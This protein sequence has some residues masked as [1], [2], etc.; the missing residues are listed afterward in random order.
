[1]KTLPGALRPLEAYQQFIVWKRVQRADRV[2]KVPI[3]HRTGR[4]ASAH[5]PAIWLS[6]ADAIAAAG[7]A[8]LGVGFTFTETD[9]FFFLDIDHC[10]EPGGWSPTALG[11]L[12]ALHG[13]AVEVS[14]SGEGLHVFGRTAALVHGTKNELLGLELYTSKR[15]VALTGDRAMGSADVDLTAPLAAI[16]AQHFPPPAAST[17]PAEWTTEPAEAGAGVSDDKDLIKRALRSKSA[18]GAFGAKCTF[19][20]LWAADPDRLAQFYPA[21]SPHKAYGDSEADA[22]LAQHLAFWTGGDCEQIHRLM[23]ASGLVREKWGREDYLY[24]TITNA[25]GVQTQYYTPKEN[26]ERIEE[27]GPTLGTSGPEKLAGYQ[28]LGPDAQIDHFRGCVYVQNLH[29][30]FTPN[31]ALLKSDQFN[32]T[33]GGY[34]FQRDDAGK[35]STRKAWEAF[36]ES[37][38]VRYPKAEGICFRPELPSGG[39]ITEEG[40]RLV[41]IY[42][43]I[44]TPRAPGDPAPFLDHLANVLPVEQDQAILL[45]YLAACVQHKGVKFQWCPLIQGADGNGKTLFTRCVAY[46][47]GNRYTHLPKA[48]DIDNKFNAWISGK[49]FIGVEDVFV[50]ESKREVL[51]A[52]KPLITNDRIEIHA[53][54]ADQTTG[55]NRANFVLNANRRDAIQKTRNDRRFAV[56]FTA[57]QR[58]DDLARDGLDGDYFPRLYAWLRGGGYAIVADYLATYPIPEHLNPAGAC[59][60]A[61]QTSSTDAA[62]SESLGSIEQE[63]LELVEEGKPGFAGGWISSMAIERMLASLRADRVIPRNRRRE[64]LQSLGY[65]WHPAL[66]GGRTP[67]VL[68]EEGGKPRLFVRSGHPD[69]MIADAGEAVLAYLRAQQRDESKAPNGFLAARG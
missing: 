8:G 47:V 30:A 57:Q 63:I 61:P 60:R 42:V 59:H 12:A 31:G 58:I 69:Q 15:F 48:A 51:E 65:D 45:A 27:A 44:E 46:A 66:P 23:W 14:Q 20:D 26:R 49:L 22:A 40:A 6:A 3:D 16:A 53:K 18:G 4:P 28:Y 11:I 2:D 1:M 68:M 10:A 41:N 35:A 54:G 64:M 19:A 56:F 38:V 9:P 34:E 32:A 39:I 55:D 37:Q 36:T 33:Y 50:P 29:R 5:D 52:L 67:K 13:A 43:P 24:R 25:A 17:A 21:K 7:L 62:V